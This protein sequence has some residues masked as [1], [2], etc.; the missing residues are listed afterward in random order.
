MQ[1]REMDSGQVVQLIYQT[2]REFLL[3]WKPPSPPP[4]ELYDLDESQGDF[5]IANT[6]CRYL[7]I[8]FEASIPLM[9]ADLEFSQVEKLMEH[10]ANH[11]LLKYA[12]TY[13]ESHLSHLDSE[14]K[15]T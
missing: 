10:L 14:N 13:F 12:I 2:V 4:A 11:P 1:L 7:R 9:E 5:E 15:F 3:D 8:A 6:C